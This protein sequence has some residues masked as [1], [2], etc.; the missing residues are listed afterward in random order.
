MS[1]GHPR[2]RCK[3]PTGR[4]MDI[5]DPDPRIQLDVRWTPKTQMPKSNWMSDGYPRTRLKI[6]TG[7][8]MP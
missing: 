6:P 8:S 7:C 1:D 3:N 4:P 5:Q 2:P